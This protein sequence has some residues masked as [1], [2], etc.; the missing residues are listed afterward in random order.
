M[1]IKILNDPMQMII[2]AATNLY[3]NM[4]CNIQF[5]PVKE[6]SGT[7]GECIFPENVEEKIDCPIINIDPSIPYG[8]ILE[9][10]AHELAH[11]ATPNDLDH[12]EDWENAFNA[13]FQEYNRL[14]GDLAEKTGGKW[15]Y[16][17][18]NGNF[19]ECD[20]TESKWEIVEK[21]GN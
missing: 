2:K 20:N 1:S 10:L 12:G 18:D 19:I 5:Y 11:V 17:D 21:G 7:F 15:M 3:E 8:A 9:V 4:S 6:E 13:I 14:M 16:V